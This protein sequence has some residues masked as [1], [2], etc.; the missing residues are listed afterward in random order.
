MIASNFSSTTDLPLVVI[1]SQQP[2][3]FAELQRRMEAKCLFFVC[4][5]EKAAE[6]IARHELVSG[7]LVDA[8]TPYANT[9]ASYLAETRLGH[10]MALVDPE[11]SDQSEIRA[12]Q[13]GAY[14]VC[15]EPV[16]EWVES[17]LG[18]DACTASADA[19]SMQQQLAEVVFP[20]GH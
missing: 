1:V 11:Y 10:R 13:H 7:W 12:Y 18:I 5:E 4:S 2:A 17:F 16:A 6:R 14:Y 9:L 15:G 20:E 3:R 8:N 19:E